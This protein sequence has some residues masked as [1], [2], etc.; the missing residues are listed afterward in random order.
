MHE[1][2]EVEIE[3]VCGGKKKAP[4]CPYPKA[5]EGESTWDSLVREAGYWWCVFTN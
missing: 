4:T 2:T 5:K 3:A 1:L